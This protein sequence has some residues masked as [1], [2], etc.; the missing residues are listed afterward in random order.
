VIFPGSYRGL[1]PLPPGVDAIWLHRS[2]FSRWRISVTT[3]ADDCDIEP[4]FGGT[5]KSL[6]RLLA[7]FTPEGLK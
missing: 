5:P 6:D 2:I 1:V 3:I 4:L 7:A